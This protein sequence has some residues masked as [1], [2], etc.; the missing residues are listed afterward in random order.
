MTEKDKNKN[1][2]AH[3][4]AIIAAEKLAGGLPG[5]LLEAEKVAHTFMKGV[6]GRR[7][8]GQGES[9]WQFRNYQP[10]DARR[11]IDWRQS[12]KR[13][14]AFV[15]QMEWEASQTLWLYRDASASME[16]RGYKNLPT[17]KEF[18]EVLLLALAIVALNGGEQVSLLGTAL[19]PQT[20]YNAI[21]RICEALPGQT[22]MMETTRPVSARSEAVLLSDFYFPVEKLSAFCSKLA[23]R[24]VRGCLVQV[25]DPA[26][27]SLPY[28]GRVRFQDIE[29]PDGGSVIIPQ[30]EA[31]REEYAARYK[32]HRDAVAAA[33]RSWGWKFMTVSTAQEPQATLAALYDELAAK[34][35]RT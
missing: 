34:K 10:G 4:A 16:F 9:F 21:R 28:K 26:E 35:G 14:E 18:A 13:D 20:H 23:L 12:A 27:E 3:D 2:E 5:L 7:R 32:A 11:E 25:Y 31:V 8:V 30:V 19:G 29:A 1:A 17:K 24:G 6:H 33:A 22:E 15:R